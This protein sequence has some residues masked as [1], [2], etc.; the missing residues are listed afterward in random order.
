MAS[1]ETVAGRIG[2]EDL[3]LTLIHEHFFSSDEAVTIQWPHVRDRDRE[4]GLALESAEAVKRHG[5][6]TVVETP[7]MLPVRDLPAL[8][9]LAAEADLEIGTSTGIYAY[10]LRPQFLLDRD[11]DYIASLFV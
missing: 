1:V 10:D 11:A 9:R 5:V 7:A 8:Q 4:Y 2:G 6:R 3:G